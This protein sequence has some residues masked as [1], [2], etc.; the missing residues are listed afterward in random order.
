MPGSVSVHDDL[1]EQTFP[2]DVDV[3]WT[4]HRRWAHV[5]SGE[6]VP[7]LPGPAVVRHW[8]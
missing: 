4:E 3:L 7:A 5:P 2:T 1:A 8:G 6:L